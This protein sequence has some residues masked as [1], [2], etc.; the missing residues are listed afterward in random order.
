MADSGLLFL[1]LL[2]A[3]WIYIWLPASMASRRGRSAIGWVLLSLIFSPLLSI[4]ALLV[5]GRTV[6]ATLADMEKRRS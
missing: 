2:F 1:L 3:I 4:I 5:L 6:E